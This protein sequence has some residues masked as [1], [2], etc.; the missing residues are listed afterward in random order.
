MNALIIDQGFFTQG[1]GSDF[2]LA[3]TWV[4]RMHGRAFI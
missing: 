1:L 3:A 2:K 4:S